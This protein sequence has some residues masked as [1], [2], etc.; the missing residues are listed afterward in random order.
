MKGARQGFGDLKALAKTAADN[1]RKAERQAAAR[2]VTATSAAGS[3]K[4]QGLAATP[5]APED[6]DTFR[7]LMQSVT[8]IKTDRVARANKPAAPADEQRRRRE[9]A[10][11]GQ[12]AVPTPAALEPVSDEYVSRLLT[13]D[14]SAFVRTGMAPDTLRQLRRGAWGVQAELDLHGMTVEQARPALATFLKASVEAGARC[15]RVIHGQGHHSSG[16]QAVLRDK[17]TR[18]LVQHAIVLAFAQGKEADGGAGAV[19]VLLKQGSAD[20]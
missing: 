12:A 5:A 3:A 8:P 2:P 1:Q 17:V 9:W 11:G 6:V 14:G 16:P 7:R 18:W 19:R 10:M 15:V 13:D 4:G 20:N